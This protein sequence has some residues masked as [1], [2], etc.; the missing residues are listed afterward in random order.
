MPLRLR[1]SITRDTVVSLVLIVVCSGLLALFTDVELTLV[2]WVS[3]GPLAG[4]EA[5]S[6]EVCR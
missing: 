3:C 6:S 1:P 5:R 4:D 2:R